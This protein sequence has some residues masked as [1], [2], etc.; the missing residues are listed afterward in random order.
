MTT[1]SEHGIPVSVAVVLA[2]QVWISDAAIAA[3]PETLTFAHAVM[4]HTSAQLAANDTGE[5]GKS[6]NWLGW[7]LTEALAR[8][9]GE[10]LPTAPAV[11]H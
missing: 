5:T 2:I 8:R 6:V 4:A 11:Q 1:A 7:E 10:T 9:L 3:T